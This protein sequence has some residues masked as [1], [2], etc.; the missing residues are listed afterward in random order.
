MR[1]ITTIWGA[2]AVIALAGNGIAGTSIPDEFP[3]FTVPGF[4]AETSAL[5]TM[6]WIHRGRSGP[7]ATLWDAW[8]AS[9]SLWPA[10]P[11]APQLAKRWRSTLEGRIIDKDGYVAT[12]Q[13][14][15]I[16]HPLGWPFPHWAQ[17]EGGAGWHFSF[18]DTVDA[19]WRPKDANTTAGWTLEGAR[20]AGMD[21]YGW[22]VDATAREAGV[23]TPGREIDTLQA[24][25]MQIRWKMDAGDAGAKPWIEWR[26]TDTQSFSAARRVT[27]DAPSTSVITHTAIDMHNHPQWKGRIT[28]LR[29]GLGNEAPGAHATIQALFTQY[30]TRHNVNNTAF[31]LG[32]DAYFRWTGDTAFL[33]RAMPRM[34]T[35]LR[36][37]M[38]EHHAAAE[39]IV[40][41]TWAGH[42][43]LTGIVRTKE[44]GKR[45]V[46]GRGVGNNY[47]DLMP[48]GN[49]DCYATVYYYAALRAI[50]GAGACRAGSPRM[51]CSAA[52]RPC[53]QPGGAGRARR[54]CEAHGQHRVL[55]PG[56]R[57]FC[58][59]HRHARRIA[60]LRLHIPQPRGDLLRVRHAGARRVHPVMDSRRAH[61]RR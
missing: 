7:G 30:D 26:T 50:G 45:L 60:R 55:E 34:R 22:R 40:H 13:H 48:F 52:R 56:D 51:G 20:D 10:M 3:H 35:A 18:K 12:H 15:S 24:P 36:H 33:R 16:A 54:G 14:G 53:I 44:G 38:D 23:L 25:F 31:V 61:G 42:D 4:D 58:G 8:I 5:R 28:Q 9:P 27:F 21:D 47:W 29:I 1:R 6:N 57:P 17:G 19:G 11:D 2:C 32:C 41:T 39:K 43:G 59:V 46:P 49:K 37:M